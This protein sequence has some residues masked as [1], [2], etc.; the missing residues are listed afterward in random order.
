MTLSG[1]FPNHGTDPPVFTHEK[2]P[3][4]QTAQGSLGWACPDG[5]AS[6]CYILSFEPTL[7]KDVGFVVVFK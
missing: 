4:F 2:F 3:C 5:S 7:C 1:S 6:G